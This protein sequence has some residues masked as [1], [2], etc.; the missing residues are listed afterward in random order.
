MCFLSIN[1]LQRYIKFSNYTQTA[2]NKIVLLE[3]GV[4]Y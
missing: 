3:R 1:S 4:A 2:K